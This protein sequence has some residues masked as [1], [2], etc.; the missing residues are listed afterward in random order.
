MF[1]VDI[2]IAPGGWMDDARTPQRI[3]AWNVSQ[4][5]DIS[6]YEYVVSK[7]IPMG[8]IGKLPSGRWLAGHRD[9]PEFVLCSGSIHKHARSLSPAHLLLAILEDADL[10]Q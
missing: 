10:G 7:A 1:Q 6:D 9:D 5:A 8:V 2:I 4:L 3:V